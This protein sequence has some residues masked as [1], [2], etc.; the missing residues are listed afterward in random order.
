LPMSHSQRRSTQNQHEAKAKQ[1]PQVLAPKEFVTP[2]MS[3][4][5]VIF[6][7]ATW[8]I[9]EGVIIFIKRVRER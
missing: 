4:L 1:T 7:D 8:P 5:R 2:K 6:M 9:F 3:M